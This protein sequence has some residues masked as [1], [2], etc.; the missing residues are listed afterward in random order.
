MSSS[1]RIPISEVV[2]TGD[3]KLF[4]CLEEL[5][6]NAIG[7]RLIALGADDGE[8]RRLLIRCRLNEVS[9]EAARRTDLDDISG[10]LRSTIH[11]GLRG[12]G[13]RDFR[14]PADDPLHRY[15]FGQARVVGGGGG[16]GQSGHGA[17]RRVRERSQ[18]VSRYPGTHPVPLPF[19]VA[20]TEAK[21]GPASEEITLDVGSKPARR[22]VSAHVETQPGLLGRDVGASSEAGIGTRRRRFSPNGNK[23]TKSSWL[24]SSI[25]LRPPRKASRSAASASSRTVSM[26][27]FTS[28]FLAPAVSV[29]GMMSSE[30]AMT[31][32]F[33]EV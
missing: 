19:P 20:M 32:S 26:N 4:D 6:P 13:L 1:S 11:V 27:T 30:R 5:D 25:Q 31:V 14:A 17:D 2:V 23:L 10:Y 29:W 3:R 22:F 18:R 9:T 28:A 16:S 12:S 15:T 24:R 7:K 21:G 33:G 8:K